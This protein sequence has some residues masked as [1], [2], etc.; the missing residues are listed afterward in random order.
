MMFPEKLGNSKNYTPQCIGVRCLDGWAGCWEQLDRGG[1]GDAYGMWSRFPARGLL[2]PAFV[3]CATGAIFGVHRTRHRDAEEE[4]PQGLSGSCLVLFIIAAF[5]RSA[6]F[7]ALFCCFLR[8]FSANFFQH[9][10][11]QSFSAIFF[12]KRF[13]QFFLANVFR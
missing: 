2:R 11:Q 13:Q 3:N 12:G 7:F 8:K 5:H 10:F 6:V 4:R 9:F 1:G